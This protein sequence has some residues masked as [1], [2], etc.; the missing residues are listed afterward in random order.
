V[1]YVFRT[2]VDDDI[3]LNA[4]CLK[5]LEI[6]I[7]E[8]SMLKP[9]YPAAVVAGN[10]ETSMCITNALYG[11]LGVLASAQGTM[12]NFTFGNARYQYYET[13]S[14][15]S[16]AGVEDIGDDAATTGFDGTDV[17]QTHMTNSRLTDPEVLEFRYPVRLESYAI[18]PG[19]GGAGRWHGGNGGDRRV[20]FLEAMTA[21]ILANSRAIAPF[22]LAGGRAGEA[23]R[24]WV[25]RSDG[26]IEPMGHIGSVEMNPGDVYV[27]QTPGGGGFGAA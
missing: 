26:R 1:L 10:V 5:P 27:I 17:V 24:N 2:L 4:G 8:G 12:N 3:P 20:R 15:G 18:R 13:I 22:G 23:G 14:G 6:V 16:G 11:A 25:E 9:D 19:S 21:S 7:P